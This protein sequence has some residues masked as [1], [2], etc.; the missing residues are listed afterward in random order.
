L[1]TFSPPPATPDDAAT[2]KR[3]SD[4]VAANA[5]Q[6]GAKLPPMPAFTGDAETVGRARFD[7]IERVYGAF[8]DAMGG[9]GPGRQKALLVIARDACELA[10]FYAPGGK[11]APKWV[12][13]IEKLV[14]EAQLDPTSFAEVAAKVEAGAP[15]DD[16][17]RAVL[18]F[19]TRTLA[20]L[21]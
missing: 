4:R 6:V 14:P 3:A 20:A 13:A 17:T 21:R 8:L 9:A 16:V 18:A 19:N 15:S 2:D 10:S 12:A 1:L 7:H 5:A 11:S